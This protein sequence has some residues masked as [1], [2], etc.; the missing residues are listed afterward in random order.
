MLLLA[1]AAMTTQA[2]ELSRGIGRY[3]GLPSEFY[4]PTMQPSDEYGNLAQFRAAYHSSCAGHNQTAQLITDGVVEHRMPYML[5]VSTKDTV[6]SSREQEYTLDEVEWTNHTLWGE[7]AWLEYHFEN[8][9]VAPDAIELESNFA[10]YPDRLGAY[11]AINVEGSHDGKTWTNLSQ[12]VGKEIPYVK[13][14]MVFPLGHNKSDKRDRAQV[15]DYYDTLPL[16]GTE[17]WE[18]IR[19]HHYMPGAKYWRINQVN[20][21]SKGQR[22]PVAPYNQYRSAWVSKGTGQEWVYVDLGQT[23]SF[24]K[25]VLHWVNRASKAKIQVSDDARSWKDVIALEDKSDKIQQASCQGRG[26]YVRLLMQQSANGEPYA[27]GEFAVMGKGVLKAVPHPQ[28]PAEPGRITL[29]GGN[30][31]LTRSDFVSASGEKIASPDFADDAWQVATVPGT[32]LTSYINIGAV[33]DPNL[34]DN[35]SYISDSY[36]CS[37]FWYRNTFDVPADFV[38]KSTQLHFDGINWKANIYLNG[39][40]LARQEGAY[41]RGIY[42]VTGLLKAGTNY[43]AVEIER[44]AHYGSIKEK[45]AYSTDYNGGPLGADAPTF[46]PSIGWD[47]ITTVRGR[48]IGIWN[49]VYLTQNGGVTVSDPLVETTIDKG[50]ASMTATVVVRNQ[51]TSATEAVVKGQIGTISFQQTVSLAAGEEK[52]V[53]FSPERFKQ[54]DRQKMQLWWPRGYGKPYLYDA[55]FTA[56]VGGKQSDRCS[57]KAG[58]RQMTY[59]TDGGI[60][61]MYVNG[62]RFIGR[63]GNWGFPEQNLLYRQREYDEAIAYHA[64]MN[65]TMIRNWVGQIGDEA[66]YEACDRHGIMVWQDFWLANPADGFNPDD[67][68]MFMRNAKDVVRRVRRHPSIALYC[69]RNEGY[70][71]ETLDKAMAQLVGEQHADMIYF[72]SSADD[73]VS[74]RGPYN[75]LQPSEYF[76]LKQ[77]EDR[78]HSERGMPCV[79]NY[80]SLSRTLSPDALWPQSEEWGKH[81][82]TLDGAQ[83]GTSFNGIIANMLRQPKSAQEFC[84]IAQMINYNGYR[85][86]FES[87]SSQRKGLLLWMTHPCWPSMVW[88]T[89]DYYL[90]PTAAYFGA[91]KANEPLHLQWNSAKDEVELVN[92]S[93][94]SRKVQALIQVFDMNG[95]ETWRRQTDPMESLEDTT[96]PLGK[97]QWADADVQYLR[98]TI[99][100]AGKPIADNFYIRGREES[101][102]QALNSLPKADVSQQFTSRLVGDHYEG[103]ITLRN[104]S[105][106]PALFLRLILVDAADKEQILPVRYEDNYVS[107]MP[108]ETR[109]IS[110]TWKSHDMRSGKVEMLVRGLE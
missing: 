28:A 88:Q 108:G 97:P 71:P 27:L 81:D 51:D 26:R 24:D 68:S 82:Y 47:W 60:L 94:G 56:T 102:Y 33:P 4:G 1:V 29:S 101:N 58:I 43:L 35:V 69:G 80:E 22:L 3:P 76:E 18:Y 34:A 55:S 65:M 106:S 48:N 10:Y 63:G 62:R 104:N 100:E 93:A 49:E 5:T 73:I 41:I 7:D 110:L 57:Y 19:L 44:N 17:K 9:Q 50:L 79:M 109:T 67:E 103:K 32:V 25:V 91:K 2:Q 98:L 38:A 83:R 107:L 92:Y 36:F 95:R 37:N 105:E 90:D 53:T 42:D 66:F 30:W 75:A 87:R 99:I 70:P 13:P 86:M 89:Y 39:K 74:G 15:T 46:H 16:E 84:D 8:W 64:D 54:L 85:A 31:R 52:T 72:P 12:K 20:F 77:G 45:N 59:S 11:Y 96:K 6:F 14:K 23:A 21:L 40:K 61:T 78:F